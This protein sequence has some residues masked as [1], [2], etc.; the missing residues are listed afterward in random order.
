M[1]IKKVK[2]WMIG[3]I[4]AIVVLVAAATSA[5]L[6]YQSQLKPVD[7][8]SQQKSRIDIK[9]GMVASQIASQLK[10]K[11]L[12][13]SPLAMSIYLR[14][15][16]SG[17]G[18]QTGVY[19]VS[20]SQSLPEIVKHLTSGKS[21]EISITFVPGAMIRDNSDKPADSKQDVTSVLKRAG[22]SDREIEVALKA[23]YQSPVLKGRP[24]GA[25][26]EGY[27]YGETYFVAADATAEQML[28]RAID[29]MAS[30]VKQ[31]DLEAKFAKKG[32]S[33][34]EGITLAS[35]IEREVSC[36]Q[37]QG[38][39]DQKKVAQVFFKRLDEDMSLGADAT[40]RYA[41]AQAGQAPTVDFDSPYNTR[42]HR[43]LPPGPISVP[44]LGALLAVAEPARG[45]YLYFVSGDDGVNYFSKTEAEHI[46][47]TNRHCKVNCLL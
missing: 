13:R 1:R 44:G 4:A 20:Q 38:C 26:L 19:S 5:I 7:A 40:F 12:I 34:Y 36:N 30:V 31:Y 35:I 16:G 18:F 24:V 11:N 32:L 25:G 33:L 28:K 21:D 23:N 43:G 17:K 15:N 14:L 9:Q 46:E 42:V 6:W 45:E 29:Q 41:A 8:N 37:P 2:W 39:E 3:L 47:L 10:E 22:F 27:I